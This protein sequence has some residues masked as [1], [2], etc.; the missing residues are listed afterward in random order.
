MVDLSQHM[1]RNLSVACR[2]ASN[3]GHYWRTATLLAHCV[4]DRCFRLH[5]NMSWHIVRWRDDY[6]SASA[7][8]RSCLA[9]DRCD[10]PGDWL[11]WSQDVSLSS[12]DDAQ[13]PFHQRG[14]FPIQS[15]TS[16]VSTLDFLQLRLGKN[17]LGSRHHIKPDAD[18]IGDGKNL[19][20]SIALS[21]TV[22]TG[23]ARWVP[24]WSARTWSTNTC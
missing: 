21:V 6:P 16:P 14:Q 12:T 4:R 8:M 5:C 23:R 24:R 7:F 18:V 20:T 17:L 22:P 1:G 19:Y 11:Y 13:E 2:A 9:I 3:P 10:I 15:W